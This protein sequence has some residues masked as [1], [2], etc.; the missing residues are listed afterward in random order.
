MPNWCSNRWIITGK[1]DSLEK[2]EK[3]LE[4]SGVDWEKRGAQRQKKRLDFNQIV[5]IPND[6]IERGYDSTGYNWCCENWGTKWNAG[7]AYITSTEDS[8]IYDF[9]TAWTPAYPVVVA[10]AQKF[11]QLS[12]EFEYKEPGMGFAGDGHLYFEKGIS[13][14]NEYSESELC[15]YC[16]SKLEEGS[17]S[18]PCDASIEEE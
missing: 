1:L 13:T 12:I 5:P 14:H 6:I 10:L 7:D 9:D 16:A 11:P 8:L 3:T 4:G 18:L 2:L 17:C 15:E